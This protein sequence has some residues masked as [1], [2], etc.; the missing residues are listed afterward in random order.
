MISLDDFRG[1]GSSSSSSSYSRKQTGPFGSPS[2]GS[3]PS[4][5][6]KDTASETPVKSNAE[7]SG[8]IAGGAARASASGKA[9]FGS[10][11]AGGSHFDAN[12][13]D[14]GRLT[15]IVK[16][17]SATWQ[18]LSMLGGNRDVSEGLKTATPMALLPRQSIPAVALHCGRGSLYGVAHHTMLIGSGGGNVT[19]NRV[20]GFKPLKSCRCF[21]I[22]FLI[23]DNLMRL[24]LISRIREQM[25][26]AYNILFNILLLSPLHKQH[27]LLIKTLYAKW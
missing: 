22:L 11:K 17:A 7:V 18:N 10:G 15:V 25:T 21:T 3:L 20:N 24:V 4:G 14:D 16:T 27:P 1:S 19:P 23:D 13:S 26:H 6:D 9:G 5:K 2:G 12:A 8:G